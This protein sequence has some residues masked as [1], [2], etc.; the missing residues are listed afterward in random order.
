MFKK[1]AILLLLSVMAAFAISS[2]TPSDDAENT[3]RGASHLAE[4]NRLLQQELENRLESL[5]FLSVDLQSLGTGPADEK[6]IRF[7]QGRLSTSRQQLN[8]LID[9]SF[10]SFV[11]A[12]GNS[13][14]SV[15]LQP[16]LSELSSALEVI[17][18]HE[19]PIT[20]RHIQKIK[21]VSDQVKVIQNELRTIAQDPDFSIDNHYDISAMIQSINRIKETVKDFR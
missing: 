19:E 5:Q 1:T 16:Y 4:V 20:S 6:Q 17:A 11:S 14:R 7:L 13:H 12:D 18:S 10:F 2:C 9:N 21:Q 8:T 15:S 3:Q